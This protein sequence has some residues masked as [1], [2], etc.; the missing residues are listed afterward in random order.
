MKAESLN[1]L[2]SLNNSA[3]IARKN[4]LVATLNL[5]FHHIETSNGYEVD[6]L[7]VQSQFKGKGFARTML[8][9]IGESFGKT[10]WLTT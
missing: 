7:Y 10:Y 2:I 5:E 6:T 3:L 4:R 9:D 1:G 8:N